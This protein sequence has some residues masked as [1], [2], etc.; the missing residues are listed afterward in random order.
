MRK[1]RRILKRLNHLIMVNFGEDNSMFD[2]WDK[3]GNLI[4]EGLFAGLED[5]L[6]KELDS[7]LQEE[8]D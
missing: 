2:L 4:R 1:A 6:I 7:L 5:S 3:E 8:E